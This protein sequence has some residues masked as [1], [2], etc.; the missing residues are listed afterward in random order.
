MQANGDVRVFSPGFQP[1]KITAANGT[2][3]HLIVMEDKVV[4]CDQVQVVGS[5]W[6]TYRAR[7]ER[8]GAVVEPL[9]ETP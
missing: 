2:V 5:S 8:S 3:I 6:G 4:A 7:M 9:A 1:Y